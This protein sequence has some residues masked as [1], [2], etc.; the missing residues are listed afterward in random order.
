MIQSFCIAGV[1]SRSSTVADSGVLKCPTMGV[2]LPMSPEA[3]LLV[4][5]HLA[6]LHI[7][8]GL[9]SFILL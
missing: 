1:L 8:G 4:H 6:L 7:I 9:N 2:D 5:M 3:L